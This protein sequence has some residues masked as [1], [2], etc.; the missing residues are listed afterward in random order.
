M[1]TSDKISLKERYILEENKESFFNTLVKNSETYMVMKLNDHINQHGLELPAG[2]EK[3][4]KTF[5][6]NRGFSY[7]EKQK[8]EFKLLLLRVSKSKD[9]TERAI[10]IKEY[11]EKFFEGNH[12]F[13]RPANVKESD[14]LKTVGEVKVGSTITDCKLKT[15]D[16]EHRKTQFFEGTCEKQISQFRPS[17]LHLFDLKRLLDKNP[18][19]FEYVVNSVKG[20][21]YEPNFPKYLKAYIKEKKK[22]NKGA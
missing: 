9:D 14:N 8:V 16:F 21:G 4:L 2:T 18:Y 15:G 7:D 19:C 13:H 3:E 22:T 6:T 12:N 5:I 20:F 10:H 1:A 11:K 17:V